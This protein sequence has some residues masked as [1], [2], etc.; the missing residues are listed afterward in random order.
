MNSKTQE[1]AYSFLKTFVKNAG[2]S[3]HLPEEDNDAEDEDLADGG[4]E[5][6]AAKSAKRKAKNQVP[7]SMTLSKLGL[8]GMALV[9]E[10]ADYKSLFST[11]VGQ[12]EAGHVSALDIKLLEKQMELLLWDRGSGIGRWGLL[13]R[14]RLFTHTHTHTL[15]TVVCLAVCQCV[16]ASNPSLL[17]LSGQVQGQVGFIR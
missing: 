2:S 1:G 12:L 15:V 16:L 10:S 11:G 14:L 7:S 13:F 17:S 4:G 5:A 3:A 6:T 9:E 8:C